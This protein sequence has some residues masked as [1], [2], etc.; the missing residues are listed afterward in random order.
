MARPRPPVLKVTPL[1]RLFKRLRHYHGEHVDRHDRILTEL[2]A[3]TARLEHL[4]ASADT[5]KAAL[6]AI[7]TAT[8]NIAADVAALKAQIGTGMSQADVDAV[9]ATLDATVSKLEAIA[10][11]TPDA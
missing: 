8:N 6:A 10:A 1:E 11:S 4:M 3:I 2:C 7:D 5:M 9:Q